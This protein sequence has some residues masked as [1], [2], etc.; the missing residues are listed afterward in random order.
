MNYFFRN[1]HLH[2]CQLDEL[3][4]FIHKKEG[5]LTPLEKLAEVYG[6]AWVWIAFSP[7]CKLVP[8]WVVGKR[9]LLHA[10]RLLFRL[11][12]PLVDRSRQDDLHRNVLEELR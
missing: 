11:L 10:R 9:T 4:T 5:P 2:E 12:P 7:V 8:A 3:W 1:L 6:D